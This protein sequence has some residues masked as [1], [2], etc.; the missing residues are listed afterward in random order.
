[1]LYAKLFVARVNQPLLG[2]SVVGQGPATM[3]A[4]K[5]MLSDLRSAAI[6]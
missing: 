6:W 1:M 2:Q 5:R 4:L 3:P